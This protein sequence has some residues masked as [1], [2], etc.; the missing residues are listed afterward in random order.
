M[1]LSKK[2]INEFKE[3]YEKEFGGKISDAQAREMG[4]NLIS[5]FKVI[6][7]PLPKLV[8]QNLGTEVRNHEKES[9]FPKMVKKSRGVNQKRY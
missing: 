4:E 7:R 3:I 2:A 5:L 9:H 1:S 8:K 6:Y